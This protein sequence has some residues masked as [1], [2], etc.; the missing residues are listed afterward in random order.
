MF[1]FVD[2]LYILRPHKIEY[3]LYKLIRR[4]RAWRLIRVSTVFVQNAILKFEK[5]KWKYHPTALK[6]EMDLSYYNGGKFH[7][8]SMDQR[9]P[10]RA[11]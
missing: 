2:Y 10:H 5:K 9:E 3:I 4:H 6:T 11:Y 7:S 8:A 1:H